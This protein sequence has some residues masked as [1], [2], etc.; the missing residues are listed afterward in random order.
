MR[1]LFHL[2][3]GELHDEVNMCTSE[4]QKVDKILCLRRSPEHFCEKHWLLCTR[5]LFCLGCSTCGKMEISVCKVLV[6]ITV[7]PLKNNYFL[8]PKFDFHGY[9]QMNGFMYGAV[10]AE[11][12]ITHIL[13][14]SSLS[15]YY[16]LEFDHRLAILLLL[17][18]SVSS[19]IR[20]WKHRTAECCFDL[21]CLLWTSKI[22]NYS[23][24]LV[25]CCQWHRLAR[26]ITSGWRY[27][28][29]R[30]N[31]NIFMTVVIL[32]L[33]LRFRNIKKI[34]QDEYFHS[35][36]HCSTLHLLFAAVLGT[37]FYLF[38]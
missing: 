3:H 23:D 12:N 25:R 26:F 17:I 19:S 10:F 36:I 20:T 2:V 31:R 1:N 24:V 5:T 11:K 35:K 22:H 27:I 32:W 9:Q 30:K 7:V 15:G 4:G 16:Q 18:L 37:I 8:H 13:V 38:F 28:A 21:L 33:C 14:T 6:S 29:W 34:F